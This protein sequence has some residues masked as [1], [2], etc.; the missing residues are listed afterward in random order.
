MRF[1]VK[2]LAAAVGAR[3]KLSAE[4]TSELENRILKGVEDYFAKNKLP[5]WYILTSVITLL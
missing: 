2:G 3:N 5:G 4:K 1:L